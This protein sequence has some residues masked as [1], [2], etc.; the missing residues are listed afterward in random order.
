MTP[1]TQNHLID[2]RA[3]QVTCSTQRNTNHLDC[4]PRDDVLQPEQIQ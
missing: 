1:F 4:W 2:L 3:D